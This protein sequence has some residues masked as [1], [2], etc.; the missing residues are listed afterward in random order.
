MTVDARLHATGLTEIFEKEKESNPDYAK[1][2]LRKL[3]VDKDSIR[4]I[5]E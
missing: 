2:I 3:K 4:R 5:F 1:Y